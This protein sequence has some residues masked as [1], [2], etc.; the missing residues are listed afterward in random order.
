MKKKKKRKRITHINYRKSQ[1]IVQTLYMI[2]ILLLVSNISKGF[3]NIQLSCWNNFI[4]NN[5]HKKQ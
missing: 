3:L 1:F 4:I 2:Q 5:K